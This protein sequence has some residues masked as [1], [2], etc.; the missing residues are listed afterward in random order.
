VEGALDEVLA[1]ERA[2]DG[3]PGSARDDEG[4]ARV[5]LQSCLRLGLYSGAR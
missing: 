4:S 5:L 1:L 2:L 3:V